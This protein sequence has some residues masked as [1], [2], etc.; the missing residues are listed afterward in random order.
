MATIAILYLFR[1]KDLRNNDIIKRTDSTILAPVNGVIIKIKKDKEINGRLYTQFTI[2]I[3]TLNEWGFYLPASS[4]VESLEKVEG[5][6]LFRFGMLPSKHEWDLKRQYILKLQTKQK[7]DIIL[8]VFPC[9]AG[10]EPD[11]WINPGDRGIAGACFGLMPF[12]GIVRLC[13]PNP[14]NLFVEEGDLLVTS[15]TV[16]ANLQE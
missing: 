2:M 6:K 4:E 13:L 7:K 11:I 8:K 12:G 14:I 10:F 5:N 3:A 16:M 9:R 1:K 15:E